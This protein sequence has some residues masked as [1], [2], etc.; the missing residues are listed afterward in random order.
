MGDDAGDGGVDQDD[1]DD[2]DD[3]IIVIEENGKEVKHQERKRPRGSEQNVVGLLSEDDE[4][5]RE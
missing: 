1:E 5:D 3:D 2:D 4:R